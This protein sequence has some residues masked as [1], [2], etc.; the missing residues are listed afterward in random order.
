MKMGG[1]GAGA[2]GACFGGLR[3]RAGQDMRF[4]VLFRVAA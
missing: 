2:V 4:V 1:G 3:A